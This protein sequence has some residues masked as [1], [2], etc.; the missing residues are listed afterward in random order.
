MEQNPVTMES[1]ADTY[2]RLVLAV[3][4]HDAD[5]V[6]AYYGPPGVKEE[7]Q[8]EALPLAQIAELAKRTLG[9]L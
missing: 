8:R 1:I 6:D 7:V 3:G 9:R 5:Y 4:L 2:V